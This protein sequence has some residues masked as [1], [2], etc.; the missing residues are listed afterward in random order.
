MGPRSVALVVLLTFVMLLSQVGLVTAA[1][2]TPVSSTCNV[3]S[4]QN[5]SNQLV[6]QV[7][8]S[9]AI[10]LATLSPSFV[11]DTAG[12][13]VTYNSFF[14]DW[15][16]DSTCR[17]ASKNVDVVFDLT[18]TTGSAKQLVAV[19]NPS[20]SSVEAIIA[21]SVG[22][23]AGTNVTSLN[24]D[25]YVF[26]GASTQ[27]TQHIIEAY[28]EWD[29]PTASQPYKNACSS[30]CDYFVW[31]GL[32]PYQGGSNAT[33]CPKGCI[34]QTGSGSEVVCLPTCSTSYLIWYQFLPHNFVDCNV[35]VGA[36]DSIASTSSYS[37]GTYYLSTT[38]STNMN[39]CGTSTGTIPGGTPYYAQM[40]GERVTA[41]SLTTLA[42][43]STTT[44][45]DL[46]ICPSNTCY[47]G[48][49]YYQLGYYYI[50]NMINSGHHNILLSP[51]SS[52]GGSE[53]TE[54]WET[55]QGT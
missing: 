52:S 11:N 7:N 45:Y 55:S 37:S 43:F 51:V 44:L 39:G 3:T 8:Q 4:I 14:V 25:G 10:S 2:D 33:Y 26:Y 32:S 16:Y 28:A 54:T 42:K 38:D 47:S 18:Q 20:I 41:P 23:R 12:Y 46:S 5:Q 22:F 40:I 24:W 30:A 36:G 48:Y 50:N 27:R 34:A 49:H 9:S 31:V 1:G 17:V 19:E 15:S 13:N 53:F 21:R 35:T 29:M 6:S